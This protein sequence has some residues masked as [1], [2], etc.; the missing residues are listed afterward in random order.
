MRVHQ[1]YFSITDKENN[2]DSKFLFV[3]NSVKEKDRD[4]RVIEGNERVLKAR[5]SD[6]VYFF[7]NDISNTF[8][9]WNEKLKHVLFYESL[10]HCM[11]KYKNG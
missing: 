6:A 2:L 5:L 3:A 9:N 11:I 8:E 7:E 4:F 10:D 1:K